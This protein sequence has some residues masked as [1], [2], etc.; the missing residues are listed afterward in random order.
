MTKKLTLI[1]VGALVLLWPRPAQATCC[2]QS[3]FYCLTCVEGFCSATIHD[4]ACQCSQRTRFCIVSG[5]CMHGDCRIADGGLHGCPL[6]PSDR[7]R[8]RTLV[9]SVQKLPAPGQ[10]I[11]AFPR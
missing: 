8:T 9:A 7:P 3:G 11:L 10:T 2:A 6:T 4:S 1:A 5:I